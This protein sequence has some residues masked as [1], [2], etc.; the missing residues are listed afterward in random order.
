MDNL[1]PVMRAAL[2]PYAPLPIDLE[3]QVRELT[4]LVK[5]LKLQQS[6]DARFVET[7]QADAYRYRHLRDDFALDAERD[8]DAFADL[9]LLTGAAFDAVIDKSLEDFRYREA[10]S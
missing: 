3:R 7:V 4:A 2:R 5:S 9:A 1:H 8:I 10:Q 6:A